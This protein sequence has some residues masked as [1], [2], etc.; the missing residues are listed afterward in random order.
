MFQDYSDSFSDFDAYSSP[1]AERDCSYPE[2]N[3]GSQGQE[4][5][6][7]IQIDDDFGR[8]FSS[9]QPVY[10]YYQED[11]KQKKIMTETNKPVTQ[12]VPKKKKTTCVFKP[13]ASFEATEMTVRNL[14]GALHCH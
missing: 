5:T 11:F 1:F 2:F 9:S 14:M 7:G 4:T 12:T 13:F 10:D 6:F 3:F 8:P